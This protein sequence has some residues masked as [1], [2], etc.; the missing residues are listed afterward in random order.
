MKKK[1]TR[2]LPPVIVAPPELLAKMQRLSERPPVSFE[3]AKAQTDLMLKG[4]TEENENR[5]E[6]RSGHWRKAG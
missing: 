5:P 6:Q 1:T 4:R 3:V 2:E